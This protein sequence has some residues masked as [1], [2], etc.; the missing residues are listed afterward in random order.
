[1]SCQ[2]LDRPAGRIRGRAAR[3][4]QMERSKSSRGQTGQQSREHGPSEEE[5]EKDEG[6]FPFWWSLSA[7]EGKCGASLLCTWCVVEWFIIFL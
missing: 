4:R 1:M 3:T 7:R 6:V 5:K 2:R